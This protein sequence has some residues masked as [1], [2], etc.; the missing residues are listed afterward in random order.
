MIRLIRRLIR[1]TTGVVSIKQCLHECSDN[2]F[3][4]V[5]WKYLKC[6]RP[7]R[8]R[9]SFIVSFKNLDIGYYYNIYQTVGMCKTKRTW[10]NDVVLHILSLFAVPFID[11]CLV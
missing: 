11:S 2:C 10:V 1:A 9:T 8:T 4:M 5:N 3:A 7:I 6:K